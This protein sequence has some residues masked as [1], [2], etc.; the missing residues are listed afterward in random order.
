[1]IDDAVAFMPDN[2]SFEKWSGDLPEKWAMLKWNRR[3]C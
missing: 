1:M 2:S 3:N